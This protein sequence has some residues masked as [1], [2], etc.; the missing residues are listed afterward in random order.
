MELRALK[1]IAGLGLAVDVDCGREAWKLLN[2]LLR[3]REGVYSCEDVEKGLVF[4]LWGNEFPRFRLVW[5]GLE[6]AFA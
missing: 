4:N 6:R 5:P 1:F 2:P 3:P